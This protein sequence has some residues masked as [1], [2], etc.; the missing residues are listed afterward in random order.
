MQKILKENNLID[1]NK[2][3]IRLTEIAVNYA[4]AGADMLCPS[5][6]MDGRIALMKQELK[7]L[8]LEVGIIAMSAKFASKLYRPFRD[9]C[10]STP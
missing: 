7:K 9:V 6:M 10:N 8:N 2:S 4:L 3:I 5:D 1:N